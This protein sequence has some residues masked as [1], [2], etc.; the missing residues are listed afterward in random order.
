MQ[1][2]TCCFWPI[3]S[4]LSRRSAP[5]D[6]LAPARTTTPEPN[7]CRSLPG[8]HDL[9]IRGDVPRLGPSVGPN[10]SSVPAG[11]LSRRAATTSLST[12][13]T[14][15]VPASRLAALP[16]RPF[17]TSLT[18]VIV[19][20]VMLSLGSGLGQSTRGYRSSRALS[21]CL[22][23][24]ATPALGRA[25]MLKRVSSPGSARKASARRSTHPANTPAVGPDSGLCTVDRLDTSLANSVCRIRAAAS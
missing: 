2:T 25:R 15:A 20:G 4:S 13:A 21:P 8:G 11:C 6:T 12:V 19:L 24:G 16:S 17:S 9:L 5:A 3:L 22:S 1:Q 23:P 18:A 14:T 7:P 10:G